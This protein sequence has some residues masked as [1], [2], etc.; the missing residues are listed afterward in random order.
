MLT[1]CIG[2]CRPTDVD[3]ELSF[4]ILKLDGPGWMAPEILAARKN[5]YGV[6]DDYPKWNPRRA[7]VRAG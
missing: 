7:R 6:N 2:R 5:V 3:R 1:G 4:L